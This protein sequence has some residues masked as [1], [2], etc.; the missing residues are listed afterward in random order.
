VNSLQIEG[1]H[2]LVGELSASGAKNATLPLL[3]AALLTSEKVE[4]RNVPH[5]QDVTTMMELLGCLGVE[6]GVDDQMAL[7][8]NGA[9][10][11]EFRAHYDLVK[12]MRASFLVMGPL[13]ARFGRAEVSLPGGCAIG[14]RPVDQHL[15]G[16]AA[17]GAEI[18]VADG[19]V[20]AQVPSGKRLRGATILFD[21]VT[22]TGTENLLMAAVL[23]QGTTVLENAAREPEVQDLADCL[24]AMGARISGAGTSTITVEGVEQLHGCSHRVLP[25]RIEVGTYLVAAAATGGRITIRDARPHDLEAVIAKLR[26]AGASV[27]E[28]EDW[29]GLD[30]DGRTLSAVDIRTAV[31]PG[32]PTDMQAQ[33][34]ALNTLAK[35]TARVTETIFENRFMHIQ[36][37][38]RLGASIDFEGGN[39]AIVRGV[40]KLFG[41]PIMATDLRASSSLVIAGLAAQGQTRVDR[42]Y[43][44]DRGYE[45]LEEKLLL[46]G[47]RVQR[48]SGR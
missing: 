42:I 26:S 35:G 22:H 3:A 9:N 13:L 19:Y 44:I 10:V 15:K 30:M 41:A 18:T 38:N 32:F 8:L 23:A 5:L 48:V 37:L 21:M 12:T 28:G 36:E 1:G 6:L 45:R 33:F 24:V 2:P 47:A 43:H 14:A 39:T 7:S 46:L 29:I 4:F 11:N 31:H 27:T 17:M 16:F 34:V 25:D 40:E 20:R